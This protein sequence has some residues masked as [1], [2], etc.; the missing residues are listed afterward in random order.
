MQIR[1]ILRSPY[2]GAAGAVLLAVW[3]AFW[4]VGPPIGVDAS[5]RH[6]YVVWGF[7]AM[8]I[9]FGWAFGAQQNKINHYER[10]QASLVFNGS[11]TTVF[12][13]PGNVVIQMPEG[14]LLECD[15]KI[16]HAGV[17]NKCGIT[18]TRLRFVLDKVTPHIDHAVYKGKPMAIRGEMAP[19]GYFDLPPSDGKTA[20]RYVAFLKELLPRG[21]GSDLQPNLVLPYASGQGGQPKL[22]RRS[23]RLVFVYRLEG[24]GLPASQYFRVAVTLDRHHK[25][26]VVIEL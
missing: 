14:S 22:F 25:R 5:L 23:E 19:D 16:Y 18:L 12:A 2:A 7:V 6:Q 26:Y 11:D 3:N 10:P 8:L 13:Q 17:V 9:S 24:G 21:A 20:S 1:R 4:L 15:E